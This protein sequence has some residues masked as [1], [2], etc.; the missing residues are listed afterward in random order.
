MVKNYFII[1]L[2]L[3]DSILYLNILIAI[4]LQI[5]YKNISEAKSTFISSDLTSFILYFELIFSSLF[6]LLIILQEIYTDR[7]YILFKRINLIFF[8]YKIGEF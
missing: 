2:S 7:D 8:Y 4:I 3:N 6:S 1:I 5:D